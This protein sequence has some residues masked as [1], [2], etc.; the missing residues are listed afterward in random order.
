M[1][2]DINKFTPLIFVL[3]QGADPTSQLQKFAQ[4]MNFMEKLTTISLG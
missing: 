1:Y 3:S 4:E 2:E